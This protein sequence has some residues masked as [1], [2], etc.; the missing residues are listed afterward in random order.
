VTAYVKLTH[1]D[2]TP[3]PAVDV[4]RHR[5]ILVAI[6]AYAYEIADDPLVS[7]AVF[8]YEAAQI[9][10]TVSTGRSRLDEFFATEFS[11]DT[12]QWVHKHPHPNKLAYHYTKRSFH[13]H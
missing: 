12:G 5:R 4:E 8:D 7:D 3:R 10:P 6:W 1:E 11:P 9:D 2:G 13:V